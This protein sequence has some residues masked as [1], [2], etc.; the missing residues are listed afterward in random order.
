MQTVLRP[1]PLESTPGLPA[2]TG[3][4]TAAARSGVGGLSPGSGEVDDGKVGSARSF[5][6]QRQCRNGHLQLQKCD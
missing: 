4:T 1:R 2:N 6:W 3:A 5:D